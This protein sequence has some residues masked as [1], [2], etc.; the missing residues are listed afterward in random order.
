MSVQA[1]RHLMHLWIRRPMGRL[2]G[3][4]LLLAMLS[5]TVLTGRIHAHAGGAHD[6]DHASQLATDWSF[7]HD[8]HPAPA[9]STGD[10]TLHVH[11]AGKTSTA[12]PALPMTMPGD[13]V[14]A[15]SGCL[16]VSTPLSAAPRPP[17]RP[18][19]A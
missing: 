14:C 11:D 1:F 12:L 13:A 3:L 6:H 18:P 8:D 15:T 7:E 2:A 10:Q 9:K 4:L 17:Y 19:I 5:A 16:V